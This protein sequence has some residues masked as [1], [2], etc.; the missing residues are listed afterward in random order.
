MAI[1]APVVLFSAWLMWMGLGPL[2]GSVVAKAALIGPGAGWPLRIVLNLALNIRQWPG[3]LVAVLSGLAL[4]VAGRRR[5]RM[6]G[7]PALAGLAGLA[8]LKAC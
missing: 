3:V 8:N 1:L 6:A 4:V 2:P 5:G 7:L